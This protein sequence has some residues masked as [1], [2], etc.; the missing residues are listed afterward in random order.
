MKH[1]VK[2]IKREVRQKSDEVFM[3]EHEMG[4]LHLLVR[5]YPSETVAILK[6]NLVKPQAVVL[7]SL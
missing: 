7:A 3:R 1:P 6:K 4:M 2:I 5:K